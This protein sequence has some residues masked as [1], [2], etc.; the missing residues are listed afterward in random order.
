MTKHRRVP[1]AILLIAALALGAC[2]DDPDT[3]PEAA[4]AQDV[5]QVFELTISDLIYEPNA[6]VVQPNSTLQVDVANR[7][8]TEHTF[9]IDDLNVD[10]EIAAEATESVVF[11]LP[12]LGVLEWRCRFHPAMAGTMTIESEGVATTAT[13]SAT[14]TTEASDDLD[15]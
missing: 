6:V 3:G 14:A 13:T 2:G 4:V 5:E 8:S 1:P 7:D 15:Y 11:T 10:L 9:T 12:G